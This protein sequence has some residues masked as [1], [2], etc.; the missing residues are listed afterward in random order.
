VVVAYNFFTATG[1]E[2]FYSDDTAGPFSMQPIAKFPDGTTHDE[3]LANMGYT[4]V[5]GVVDQPVVDT[6]PDPVAVEQ[7]VLEILP[8]PIAEMVASTVGEIPQDV[9]PA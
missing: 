6:V 7:S 5:D 4:V 9:P 1:T 2:V 3:A 8:P